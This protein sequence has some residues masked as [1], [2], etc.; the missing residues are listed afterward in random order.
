MVL[1]DPRL[2]ADFRP[3]AETTLDGL[4]RSYPRVAPFR[5]TLYD[6][7]PSDFSL[8]N[9]D[10][11]GEIAL[12]AFWFATP[13]RRFD[14]AV[15]DG[16]ASTPPS[17][18]PWHGHIGGLAHEFDRLLCHEFGHLLMAATSGAAG[19]ARKE[20]ADAVADPRL[21]VSGYAALDSDEWW[22]ETFAAMRLGGAGSPQVA[23]MMAFLG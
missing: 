12:N 10:R 11:P 4:L 16:R 17:T 13:R 14:A 6:P 7:P 5:L 23:E 8:G 3:Q 20:H 9:C 2:H 18:P 15:E 21:A 22:A 19:F 1:I